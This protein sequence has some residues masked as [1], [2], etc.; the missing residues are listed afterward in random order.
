MLKLKQAIQYEVQVR[1]TPKINNL[2]TTFR[3]K[4]KQ[5][6]DCAL[7]YGQTYMKYETTKEHKKR[8]GQQGQTNT[9]GVRKTQK[10]AFIKLIRA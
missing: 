2:K 8:Q 6:A 5:N 4:V 1:N 10:Q 9:L 3:C 7:T